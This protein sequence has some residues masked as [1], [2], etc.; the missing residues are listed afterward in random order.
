[1]KIANLIIACSS[2]LFLNSCKKSTSNDRSLQFQL[3]TTNRTAVVNAPVSAGSI[4][5][6]TGTASAT[7]IKVEAK[8]SN[9]TEV[10]Y[11]S[12]IAQTINLFLPAAVSL[13]NI[14]IPPGT[15][16]EVEFKISLNQI[17][18]TPALE[19]NGQY[20]N[21]SGVI[22]PVKF[23]VNNLLEI[24]GEQNNVTITN[25]G[26]TTE[27]TLLNLAALTSG[28]SQIMLNNA[29]STGGTIIISNTVNAVLYNIIAANLVNRQ[30]IELHD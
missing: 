19:L 27:I 2:I 5:W 7:L 26:S 14:V 13:G 25:T 16:S 29:T 1:M 20:T 21:G 24:K 15:Y 6:T 9:G 30:E 11:K 22:T 4:T 8:N 18:N 17:G 10:E 28:I 3:Q 12:Q 23:V